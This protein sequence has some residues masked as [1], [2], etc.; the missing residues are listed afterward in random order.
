MSYQVLSRKWRPQNFGDVVGQGHV[1]QTIQNAIKLERIGHGYIFTGPRGVGKTTVARVLAKVLN[2]KNPKENNPCNV[3]GHCE[4]ITDGRN[5][6]VLE[7]DGASNRGIDEIRELRESVKY[8]PNSGNYRVYIIDEVHMLTKEAFNALLKTLEEPP[9]H[10]VFILATT[11]P[12]KIPQTILS[13]TQRFDFR[14]ISI[15]LISNHLVEI[16]NRE[17][18]NFEDEAINLIAK[19]ADGSMRDSLSLLD[20]VI[21]YSGDKLEVEPVRSSLGIIHDSLYINLFSGIA[22]K[23]VSSILSELDGLFNGGHSINDFISGF[24]EIMRNALVTAS[25]V[26]IKT[27]PVEITEMVSGSN[28]IFHKMDLLRI[29]ELS[30]NFE[31]KLRYVQQPQIALESLFIK[32][33]SMDS[34][35]VV[36]DVLAGNVKI[37]STQNS[38]PVVMVEKPKVVV[39]EKPEVLTKVV[40]DIPEP[41]SDQEAISESPRVATE[42][43]AEPKPKIDLTLQ[44]IIDG[45]GNVITETEKINA[46]ISNLL[47][48][49]KLEEF[50]NTVLSILL[51]ADQKFQA[52]SLQKDSS[53]IETVLLEI[54]GSKIKINFKI[55]ESSA[56]K[57]DE[58]EQVNEGDKEHPLFMKTL[59]TF[60]GEVLR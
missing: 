39:Q 7:L 25:G 10:V 36:R 51:N 54:F 59:E 13:R 4:E 28:S 17:D 55:E 47:E 56:S 24:N 43:I 14:R 60:E 16:L 30:M 27:L 40:K 53:K 18:I 22:T 23:N 38:E 45:W 9:A 58:N 2:C 37:D 35:V 32:L 20:Q 44:K 6:D 3:C 11:D 31:T 8:P 19:K 41:D 57:K 46:K 15:E 34:C 5:M 49:V 33:A 26:D 21:A 29:L 48:E 12:H 50:K 1:T 52:K 42:K